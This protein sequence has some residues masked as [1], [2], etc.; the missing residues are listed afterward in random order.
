MAA[1]LSSDELLP[2]ALCDSAI[3]ECETRECVEGR[4]MKLEMSV[5]V[6]V[7]HVMVLLVE[8]G[9]QELQLRHAD[10]Q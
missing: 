10:F 4:K 2:G 8:W 9:L 1:L 3:K 5:E 7:T 6:M